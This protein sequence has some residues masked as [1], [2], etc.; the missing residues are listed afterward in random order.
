MKK[1]QRVRDTPSVKGSTLAL[2]QHFILLYL[3]IPFPHI[4]LLENINIKMD[5]ECCNTYM[6]AWALGVNWGY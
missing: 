1:K 6:V 4:T 5:T 2:G 3:F